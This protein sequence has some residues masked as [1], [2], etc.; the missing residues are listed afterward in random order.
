MPSLQVLHPMKHL[1]NGSER[2]FSMENH[3]K[4]MKI[5]CERLQNAGLEAFEASSTRLSVS[6]MG[7]PST[8][9]SSAAPSRV[10]TSLPTRKGLES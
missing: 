5:R 4:S 1:E 6:V 10:C 8:P 2:S 3:G 9:S 7:A